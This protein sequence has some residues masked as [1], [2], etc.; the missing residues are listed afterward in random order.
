MRGGRTPRIDTLIKVASAL[1]VAPA[2]LLP[3]ITFEP[4]TVT[5]GGFEVSP[6]PDDSDKLCE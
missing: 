1:D 3:N 2:E 5:P 4:G 6:A